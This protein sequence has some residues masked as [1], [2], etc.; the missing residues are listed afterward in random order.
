MYLS[1]SLPESG[2][3]ACTPAYSAYS[4]AHPWDQQSDSESDSDSDCA[5]AM[6]LVVAIAIGIAR[7]QV[8]RGRSRSQTVPQS[9]ATAVSAA[10]L[11]VRLLS[12]GSRRS[13][14]RAVA[15]AAAVVASVRSGGWRM[16]R[17]RLAGS[18]FQVAL[19]LLSMTVFDAYVSVANKLS[20]CVCGAPLAMC[21]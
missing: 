12:A 8:T 20:L 9:P 1:E 21:A 7:A 19:L 13:A 18:C 17:R 11:D 3:T 15:V 14:A 16:R 2:W 6:M 4:A 10:A 5:S